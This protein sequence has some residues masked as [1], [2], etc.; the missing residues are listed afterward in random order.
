[1]PLGYHSFFERMTSDTRGT[2]V[3]IYMTSSIP[4]VICF[5]YAAMII[6][7][8]LVVRISM[9]LKHFVERTESGES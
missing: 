1:M 8:E 3:K 4:E 2:R 9:F 7:R 5:G 6:I